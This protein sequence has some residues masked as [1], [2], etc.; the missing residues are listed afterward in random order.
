MRIGLL[1]GCLCSGLVFADVVRTE[2]NGQVVYQSVPGN[3]TAVS[4]GIAKPS[5]GVGASAYRP[6]PAP[7][8]NL[9]PT[10]TQSSSAFH[11]PSSDISQRAGRIACPGG[12][13]R[14]VGVLV[15]GC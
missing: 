10:Y 5:P 6:S 9:Y 15:P 7:Q 11:Q 1:L 13:S 4:M 2:K 12:G 3:R 14:P 8:H